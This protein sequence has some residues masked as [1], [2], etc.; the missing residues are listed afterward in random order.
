MPKARQVRN[1]PAAGPHVS[2]PLEMQL[3]IFVEQ[4]P[5]SVATKAEQRSHQEK[6]LANHLIH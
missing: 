4:K 3:L 1:Q 2:V 5:S 6:N